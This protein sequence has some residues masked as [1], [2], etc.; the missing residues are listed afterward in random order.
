[1]CHLI[2]VNPC[3][4]EDMVVLDLQR[5][6]SVKSQYLTRPG[7]SVPFPRT[8]VVLN[9]FRYLWGRL[10]RVAVQDS[11]S[12]VSDFPLDQEVLAL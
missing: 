8:A 3:F 2:S 10:F 7:N 1:M 4:V 11:S 9:G 5:L 6:V 12:K